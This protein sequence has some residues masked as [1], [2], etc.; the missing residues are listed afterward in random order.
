MKIPLVLNRDSL[1]DFLEA[2]MGS[3]YVHRFTPDG[4]LDRTLAL[5]VDTPTRPAF[6]GEDFGTLYLTTG[7]LKSGET[8]DGLKGGIF[9]MP[10]GIAGLP[11][12]ATRI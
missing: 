9:A 6:G 4:V 8:D 5:P 2:A 1:G 10:A 7:G 12:K 3:P 11:A